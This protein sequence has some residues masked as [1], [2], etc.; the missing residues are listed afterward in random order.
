MNIITVKYWGGTGNILFQIATTIAYANKMNRPF[1]LNSHP[2]FP[3][4][5]NYTASSIGINESDFANSLQELSEDQ[6]ANN[7]PFPKN[8]NVK[9]TGFFQKHLLFDEYKLQIFRII[10]I[11]QIRDSVIPIIHSPRFQMRG[12]FSQNP[13]EITISIH[14]RRGDYENL[15]CFFLLLN[16]YYYTN[17]LIHIIN[18]NHFHFFEAKY[19]VLC[20]YEKKSAESAKKVIS[21]IQQNEII[22]QFPIEFYHFN[23]I[24]G[25]DMNITDMEELAVI[26]HCK[27]HIIANSTYSWWA[28]YIN[29]DSDNI[30]CYP[31][32]YYNHNLYYLCTEGLHVNRWTSINSW[33]ETDY[34]CEHLPDKGF[35]KIY[36]ESMR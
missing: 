36:K 18:S 34:R 32:K 7:V 9:L 13:N 15:L 31:D 16:E 19:K 25:D 22:S 12:L 8:T 21:A 2:A 5:D 28:A 4:L 6:I 29:P 20:F 35:Y 33:R 27:H 17:A 1:I 14:I 10:G 26:S 3:N 11:P 24:V 23:E 30:V